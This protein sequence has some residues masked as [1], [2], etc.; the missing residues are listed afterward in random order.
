MKQIELDFEN[1]MRYL[2]KESIRIGYTPSYLIQMLNEN[3]AVNVAKKLIMK[4]GG[5]SG[6]EKMWEKKRLDLTIEAIVIQPKY[7]ELFTKEEIEESN[8]RLKKYGF[9]F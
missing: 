7:K 3:R 1:E 2:I 5:T 9:K 6:F 4:D 8:N